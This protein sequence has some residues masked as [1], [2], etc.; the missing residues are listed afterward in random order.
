[1]FDYTV[2][3]PR[4]SSG[5]GLTQAITLSFFSKSI[6]ETEIMF[7]EVDKAEKKTELGMNRMKTHFLKNNGATMN[8]L[9]WMFLITENTRHVNLGLPFKMEDNINE[10]LEGR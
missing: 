2:S 5:N 4:Q 3:I 9:D 1:M 10:E 6:T 8:K 7:N